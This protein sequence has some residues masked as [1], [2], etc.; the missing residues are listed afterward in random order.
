MELEYNDLDRRL[1][2]LEAKISLRATESICGLSNDL[3]DVELYDGTL[4]VSIDF[5]R[6]FSRPVG[7]FQWLDN[8]AEMF[9]KPNES[10]GNVN[11][12]RWCSGGLVAPNLFL[13]AGHC[14]DRKGGTW[15]RPSRNGE[16]VSEKELATLMKVNFNF[17]LD[18]TTNLVRPDDSYPVIGMVEF[19]LGQLDYAVVELGKNKDGEIPG[20]KYGFF[21]PSAADITPPGSIL[22]VIQHPNKQ[23]KKIEAGTLLKTEAGLIYY[24]SI[25][26]L[27]GSSG[28]TVLNGDTGEIV[29]VHT[30]GGCKEFNGANFGVAIGPIRLFS[31]VL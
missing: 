27:G 6:Q 11:G 15:I 10:A 28:A 7:Q 9:S 29:G 8:L 5:V 1:E 18:G 3:Q 19:R 2:L 31:S 17:Q 22:C 20:N 4:G 24:N 26:T 12:V 13:T 14:F 16:V 21:T 30:N 25:D 23:P